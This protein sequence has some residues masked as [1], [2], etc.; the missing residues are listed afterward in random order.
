VEK[1]EGRNVLQAQYH[2]PSN[3]GK[4]R[5]S[6]SQETKKLPDFLLVSWLPDSF[7]LTFLMGAQVVHSTDLFP[8]RV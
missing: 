1:A 2:L 7:L 4:K 6:G 5:K 3:I 8:R